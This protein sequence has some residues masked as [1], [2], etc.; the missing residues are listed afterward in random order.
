MLQRGC[1]SGEGRLPIGG[2]LAVALSGGGNLL[3]ARFRLEILGRVSSMY[4]GPVAI[5]ELDQ[6][7]GSRA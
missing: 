1:Y 6:P 5:K 2:S 3:E 7:K 4:K